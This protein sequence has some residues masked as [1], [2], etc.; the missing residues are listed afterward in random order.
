MNLTNSSCLYF[1]TAFDNTAE[2][3]VNEKNIFA[4]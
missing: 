4:K 2:K 3:N 1:K